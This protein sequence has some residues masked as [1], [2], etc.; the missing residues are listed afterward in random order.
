MP[1][2]CARRCAGRIRNRIHPAPELCRAG[3]TV[4]ET[5][6]DGRKPAHPDR[7]HDEEWP[8]DHR[9]TLRD[10]RLRHRGAATGREHRPGALIHDE[11][12]GWGFQST[13]PRLFL[14]NQL[15]SVVSAMEPDK[16]R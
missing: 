3:W 15:R 2:P 13:I 6:V 9:P 11:Q 10:L 7:R 14:N 1:G 16:P 4:G 5:G 8:Y 12:Y